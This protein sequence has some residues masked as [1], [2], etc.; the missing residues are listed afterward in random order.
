[1][2]RVAI[3]EDEEAPAER[4]Q[5]YVE[6]YASE[7]LVP[8]ETVRFSDG[9]GILE[10]F[11]GDFD[12][13]LMDIKMPLVDGFTAAKEIRARD[14]DV[15]LIF[16]TNMMQY[17]VRGYSVDA[18]DYVIKPVSFLQFAYSLDRAMA[19]LE[20]RRRTSVLL[21]LPHQV[22]RIDVKGVY[23]VESRNHDVVYHSQQG[24]L[25][26]Y[27]KILEEEKRLA[28]CGFV[29]CHVSYLVNLAY[30]E[31]SRGTEAM[32]HG[33]AL[34]VSRSYKKAFFEALARYLSGT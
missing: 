11:K 28:G 23:Y 18:L 26:F 19:R 25:R 29:R 20:R 6:R 5:E 9:D 7:K 27:G 21:P 14:P 34:P 13:I 30:V 3:V 22:Q 17:A 2:V 8:M 4:L 12:I 1:M 31:S 10:N 33:E 16:V 15:P 32:V 24:D